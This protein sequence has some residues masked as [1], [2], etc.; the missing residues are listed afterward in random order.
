[1]QKRNSEIQSGTELELNYVQFQQVNGT[2]LELW[3]F[4]S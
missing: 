3:N 1:M 2:D 4:S